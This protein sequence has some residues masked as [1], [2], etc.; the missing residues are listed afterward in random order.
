[1]AAVSANRA[2]GTGSMSNNR[3]QS[4][5]PHGSSN[6]R[7]DNGMAPRKPMAAVSAPR[8]GGRPAGI[9][10]PGRAAAQA[11]P[12]KI[13]PW[14]FTEGKGAS[15]EYGSARVG[16]PSKNCYWQAPVFLENG[17][18]FRKNF[19]H[20]VTLLIQLGL[21]PLVSVAVNLCMVLALDSTQK[22]SFD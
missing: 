4:G 12:P 6:D 20:F 13:V 11:L 22:D 9:T 19:S 2:G 14:V 7:G 10:G 5:L 8:T 16:R 15:A 17:T 1:M 21:N 3:R 18:L